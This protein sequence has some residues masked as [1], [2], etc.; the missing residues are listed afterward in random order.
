MSDSYGVLLSA[1][2]KLLRDNSTLTTL[3]NKRIYSELPS[4]DQEV[5][6]YCHVE[7]DSNDF[8]AKDFTGMSHEVTIKCFSRK[9]TPQE[10]ADIRSA[11]YTALNRISSTTLALSS[12]HMVR[13]DYNGNSFLFK[14]DDGKTWQGTI[15]FTIII[16]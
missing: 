3:V 1:V 10:C 13:C 9:S 2:I 6:P 15:G 7:I 8:S 5:F 16:T 4:N 12:G 11:I 14:E